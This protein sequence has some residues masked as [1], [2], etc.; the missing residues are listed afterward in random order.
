VECLS[1][2][3][4]ATLLGTVTI[5]GLPFAT[6][7]LALVPLAAAIGGTLIW[8][9][10]RNAARQAAAR[11]IHD[12]EMAESF[13]VNVGRLYTVTFVIG[14]VLAPWAAPSPRRFISVVPGI[15]VEVIVLAFAW[16]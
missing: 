2:Y 4:P 3:Q 14:A 11:V 5:D 13:G 9:L 16:W 10:A 15:G 8:T 12:R 6:Y 7:E 1:A